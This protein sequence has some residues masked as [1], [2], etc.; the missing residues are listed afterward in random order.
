MLQKNN[1]AFKSMGIDELESIDLNGLNTVERIQVK[2]K[3]KKHRLEENKKQGKSKTARENINV[4]VSI[5][6][7]VIALLALIFSIIFTK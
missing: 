2:Q 3:I 1:P 5:I 7:A 6:S 4:Y